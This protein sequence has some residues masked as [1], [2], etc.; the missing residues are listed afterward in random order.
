LSDNL[1]HV[2][3]RISRIAFIVTCVLVVALCVVNF[4]TLF[5]TAELRLLVIMIGVLPAVMFV[6]SHA[7]Y[8]SQSS[9]NCMPIRS[10]ILSLVTVCFLLL[11]MVLL[12]V[13]HSVFR[14]DVLWLAK[15]LSLLTLS[16]IAGIIIRSDSGSGTI[17][18]FLTHLHGIMWQVWDEPEENPIRKCD[19]DPDKIRQDRSR[20]Y[21]DKSTLVVFQKTLL[22][23]Y[24]DSVSAFRLIDLVDG[25]T[26]IQNLAVLDV[27][28]GDG[29]LSAQFLRMLVS[30]GS[31]VSEI[32]MID[33]VDWSK[34]YVASL[35]AV[36][37]AGDRIRYTQSGIEEYPIERQYDIVLACH[38][39]YAPF[40]QYSDASIRKGLVNRV[41]SMREEHG[42]AILSL[43]SRVGRSYDFKQRALLHVYGDNIL[44]VAGEDL[45]SLLTEYHNTKYERFDS[46]IN[47]TEILKKYRAGDVRELESWLEYF[48][49][50]PVRGHVDRLKS[51]YALL[52]EYI[53]P[54]KALSENEIQSFSKFSCGRPLDDIVLPHKVRLFC[55]GPKRTSGEKPLGI[56]NAHQ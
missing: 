9:I 37:I 15:L 41:I 47:L 38:S 49:R 10:K 11:P 48:L 52:Q 51:L 14:V 25:F 54:V 20:I 43:A 18:A 7:A 8:E 12:V 1:R 33:P 56:S 3:N 36:G 13:R 34:E 42:I 28:G 29:A 5:L 39:L 6:F 40:D 16:T 32:A 30:A 35:G 21:V 44:D 19:I 4:T 31:T 26:N 24:T 50:V 45:T 23:P 27:G 46:W 22:C 55:V 53:V 17:R 2:V